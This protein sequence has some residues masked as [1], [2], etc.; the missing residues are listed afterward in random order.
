MKQKI[1]LGGILF[2]MILFIISQGSSKQQTKCLCIKGNYFYVE[3]AVTPRQRACGLMFRE[4]LDLDSGMLF[5]YKREGIYPFWMKNTFIPLDI[6]WIN[7]EKEVVFI[8][9][10]T[11]PERSGVCPIINPHKKAKYV[12]EL[13]GGVSDKIGLSVGDR[14]IFMDTDR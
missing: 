2:F 9:R 12:L 10:N 8:S 14:I 1:I 3:L 11:P 13:N 7:K 6:I 5:I 4:H